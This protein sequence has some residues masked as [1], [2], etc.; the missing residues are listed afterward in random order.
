MGGFSLG[1]GLG[2]GLDLDF[3]FREEGKADQGLQHR[4]RRAFF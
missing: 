4:S 2:L 1:V 3:L